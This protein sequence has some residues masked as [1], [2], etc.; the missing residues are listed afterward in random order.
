MKLHDTP[1]PVLG[2][3]TKT[4]CGL[5]DVLDCRRV[6]DKLGI[7]LNEGILNE[8]S[9]MA[10]SVYSPEN[11]ASLLEDTKQQT[12]EE[13]IAIARAALAQSQVVN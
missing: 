3:E 7:P 5:D 4:C 10:L 8:S 11:L 2:E 12:R 9:S 1:E 13:K 6:A